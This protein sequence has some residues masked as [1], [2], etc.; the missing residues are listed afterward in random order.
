MNERQATERI[1]KNETKKR[2]CK[3]KGRCFRASRG[4]W[5]GSVTS[6]RGARRRR[7]QQDDTALP[8]AGQIGYN[9]GEFRISKGHTGRWSNIC[10]CRESLP[11]C[12]PSCTYVRTHTR[13]KWHSYTL[14]RHVNSFETHGRAEAAFF[15]CA[16]KGSSTVESEER[17]TGGSG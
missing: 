11:T 4:G 3:E 10:R 1:L 13:K 16:Q 7:I 12:W 14:G 2:K 5:E 8:F 15:S 9:H 17:R 6:P